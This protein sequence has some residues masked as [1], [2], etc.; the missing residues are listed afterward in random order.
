M[1]DQAAHPEGQTFDQ[2]VC[3]KLNET[4]TRIFAS[5]PEVRSLACTIDWFGPLNDGNITHGVWL[6]GNG[7]VAAPD[8]IYG[9]IMQSLRM[10]DSQCRR[11]VELNQHLR[12]DCINLG[13]EVRNRSE[14]VKRLDEE[15]NK[16]REVLRR[17]RRLGAE[18]EKDLVEGGDPGATPAPTE[19]PQLGHPH[20]G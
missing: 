13:T 3:N 7:V 6:C 18:E 11:A 15:I 9:S 1:S 10:L 5:H 16:R 20:S 2:A 17:M 19:D 14:E 12:Q 4:F 8:A